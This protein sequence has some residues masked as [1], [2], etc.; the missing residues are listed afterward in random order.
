MGKKIYKIILKI[1]K[2]FQVPQKSVSHRVGKTQ[3]STELSLLGELS[4]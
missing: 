3:V 1:N 4:L 2:I